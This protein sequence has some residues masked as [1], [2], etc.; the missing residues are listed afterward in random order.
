MRVR[1][2]AGISVHVRV[3]PVEPG[4]EEGER[5]LQGLNP[6]FWAFFYFFLTKG[7]RFCLNYSAS[8]YENPSKIPPMSV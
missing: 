5:V 3:G 6:A 8:W 7:A 2:C 4:Q 1:E